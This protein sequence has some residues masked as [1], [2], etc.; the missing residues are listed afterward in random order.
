M[1]GAG[2][3]PKYP[4]PWIA[5]YFLTALVLIAGSFFVAWYMERYPVSFDYSDPDMTYMEQIVLSPDP[6]KGNFSGLNGGDWKAL[7]LV[8]WKGNPE[9]ALGDI[10][11]GE[12]IVRAFLKSQH[13]SP[14]E[15]LESEFLLIYADGS[16]KVKTVRHPHGFAFA[17]TGAAA[18][19]T[20][21]QPMLKL[22][23]KN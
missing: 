6:Q 4:I 3:N 13:A 12:D 17:H 1:P 15:L 7:C 19:T 20:R 21:D 16:S 5:T 11:A 8:G 18:C 22:P 14:E 23:A 2:S 9:Q 10:K